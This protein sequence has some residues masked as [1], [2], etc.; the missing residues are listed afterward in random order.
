M[1]TETPD[2]QGANYLPN[3]QATTSDVVSILSRLG[4][5]F[6]AFGYGEDAL[7][8]IRALAPKG[9][10]KLPPVTRT[11]TRN[12]LTQDATTLHDLK[13]LNETRGLYFVVNEGGDNDADIT[14]FVACFVESDTA[15]ISDQHSRLDAAPLL[16]SISSRDEKERTR[17]FSD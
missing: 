15:S 6:T 8:N 3:T 7:I 1:T 11:I 2:I 10:Q 17:L 13:A 12:S 4:D 14:R 9:R 5:F 16:P